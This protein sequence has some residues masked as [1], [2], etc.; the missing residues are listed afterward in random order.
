MRVSVVKIIAI[1]VIAIVLIFAM[2][3]GMDPTI[4]VP[5]LTMLL[6]YLVGNADVIESRPVVQRDE[7]S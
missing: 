7:G 3:F 4:G 5:L 1:A 6:G 2:L